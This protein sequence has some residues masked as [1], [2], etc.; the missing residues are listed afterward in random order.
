[1]GR[2]LVKAVQEEEIDYKDV[3]IDFVDVSTNGKEE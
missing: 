3:N 1:M 2:T